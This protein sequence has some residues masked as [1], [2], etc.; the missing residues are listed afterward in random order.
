M[1]S[2]CVILADSHQDMLEGIRGLLQTSFESVVM[3]ADG[4]S[5]FD[6]VEK[7]QPDIVVVDLSLPVSDEVNV[8]RK[9]KRLFP[10]LKFIILSVHDETTAV[11]EVMSAGAA[12]FVLKRCIATDLLSAAQEISKGN[13]YI[14]P[15][16]KV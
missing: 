11:N 16:L 13:S 12:G 2:K 10:D 15:S 9:I 3:V 14:S 8:A 4:K 6:T 5:L 1:N 7:M